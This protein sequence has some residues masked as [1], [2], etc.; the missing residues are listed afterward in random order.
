MKVILNNAISIRSARSFSTKTYLST[1]QHV[2]LKRPP[3]AGVHKLES[4]LH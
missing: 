3:I 1:H 2:S 4:A